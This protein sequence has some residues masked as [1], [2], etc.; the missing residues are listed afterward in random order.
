[1]QMAGDDKRLCASGTRRRAALLMLKS[2]VDC[3]RD[4]IVLLIKSNELH[5]EIV[6]KNQPIMRALMSW[7]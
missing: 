1:M 7:S 3:N 6:A 5:V 4:E 2:C